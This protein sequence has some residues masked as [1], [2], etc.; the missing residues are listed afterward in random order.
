MASALRA[1]E[2]GGVA[3]SLSS[4]LHHARRAW[5]AGFCTFNGLAL[6]ARRALDAGAH[7][8]LVIDLDAHCG[9]GTA[10][11]LADDPA[12]ACI[13]LAVDAFDLYPER[14]RFTLDTILDAAAY[15]PTLGRRLDVLDPAGFDLVLYNAGMDPFERCTTGG[16]RGMTTQLLAQRERTVFEWCRTKGLPIAFVL[17]G[18]YANPGFDEGELVEL[19][20]LTLAEAAPEPSPH[21]PHGS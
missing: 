10:D 6:A 7:G 21:L 9:G 5:G 4:G 20:R 18:G 15:L 17:A 16:R 2:T 13:D 1:L 19:H 14:G 12:V 8:V 3:G 11:I